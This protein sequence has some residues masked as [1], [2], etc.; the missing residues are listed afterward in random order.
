MNA[1]ASVWL[2]Y[3]IPQQLLAAI[4]YRI[5]RCTWPVVKR[6]LIAWFAGRYA[7]DLEDVEQSDLN[8][9]LC[10]NDFFIR[11]LKPAARPLAGD[12]NTLISP[13]DGCL[14]QFGAAT[15]GKLIQAKGLDYELDDLLGEP[16]SGAAGLALGSYATIYLAPHD[17]HR[18]H[19]P[20]AGTLTRTRYLPGKRFSVNRHTA[21]RIPRLFCQN[22]RVVCWFDT[23]I[24][25]LVVVFVGALNVSS[26]STRWLGEIASGRPRLWQ[27]AG[28]PLR[29]Y[30][31]G[32]EIGHFNLG[33]TVV[34]LLPRA[35]LTWDENLPAT[36]LIRL[37]QA[38]GRIA[39]VD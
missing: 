36:G 19:M 15:A 6:P 16:Q 11:S 17:Y 7:I 23:E 34:L 1:A 38:L 8:A 37:G 18:V 3:L 39:K 10:F 26:I 14:T 27:H 32:A 24:G 20:L 28:P 31:R 29:R 4:V 13:V 22:E 5:A 30:E 35:G 21:S 25:P 12:E 2:Q 33:S 9:Y